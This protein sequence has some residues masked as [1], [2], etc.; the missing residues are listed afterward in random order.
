[1]FLTSKDKL[2]KASYL[3]ILFLHY[4]H[5][6]VVQVYPPKTFSINLEYGVFLS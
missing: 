6:S 2:L 3:H 1:M 5:E 4:M